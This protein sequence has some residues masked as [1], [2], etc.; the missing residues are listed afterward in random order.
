MRRLDRA[1]RLAVVERRRGLP[2]RPPSVER[3]MWTRQPSSSV[4]E[5]ETIGAVGELHRLVL[6][7]AEHAVRQALPAST[8]SGRRRCDVITMPHH[9]LGDGPTL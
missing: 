5:P 2:R 9:V 8:T 3:S 1:E 6:D 7:R 4:L